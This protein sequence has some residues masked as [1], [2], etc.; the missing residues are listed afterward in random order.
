MQANEFKQFID[1]AFHA[2]MLN[3]FINEKE[4]YADELPLSEENKKDI[5]IAIAESSLNFFRKN[6]DELQAFCGKLSLSMQSAG[7]DYA[8]EIM[9]TSVGFMDRDPIGN[10]GEYLTD[11]CFGEYDLSELIYWDD[12]NETIAFDRGIYN[13]R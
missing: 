10:L 3:T 7:V 11:Q 6:Y 12:E 2:L 4:C 5:L 8:L 1:G 13:A 9:Q